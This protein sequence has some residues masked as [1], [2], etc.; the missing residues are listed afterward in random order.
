MPTAEQKKVVVVGAGPC[1]RMALAALKGKVQITL[2]QA[3]KTQEFFLP[4]YSRGPVT[5]WLMEPCASGSLPLP[6]G[7]LN[8]KRQV[9]V[10][11]FL[12]STVYPKLYCIGAVSNLTEPSIGPNQQGQAATIAKNILKP[13]SAPYGGGPLKYS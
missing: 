9:K 7:I 11:K 1:G 6:N 13:G 2:I 3:S 4:P 8:E 12:A 5:G 10:D